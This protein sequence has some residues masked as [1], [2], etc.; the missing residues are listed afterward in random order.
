M[1]VNRYPGAATLSLLALSVLWGCNASDEPAADYGPTATPATYDPPEEDDSDLDGG[2]EEPNLPPEQEDAFFRAMPAASDRYVFVVNPERDTLS[3]INATTRAVYTLPVGLH[4]TQ[5]LTGAL[6][7]N[8]AVVLNEGDA[9]LSLLDVSSDT[10][11]TLPI[12]PDTNYM[13]LS[14]DGKYVITWFEANVEGADNSVD[15]VRSYS[16][17]SVVFTGDEKQA[18]TSTP[19]AVALNPRGATY[20][21]SSNQALVLCDGV[22]AQVYLSA[23]PTVRLIPLTD[24]IDEKLTVAEMKVSPDGR[25]AFLRLSSSAELMVVS[26]QAESVTE[27]VSRVSLS[28]PATDMDLAS[29]NLILVD[30]AQQELLIFDAQDPEAPP[31]TLQTPSNQLVGSLVISPSLNRAVLYTTL[32]AQDIQDT[33]YEDMPLDRFSLWDL[34]TD[35]IKLYDLVKPVESVSMAETSAGDVV[36]FIHQASASS[37]LTAFN[38]K[39]AL[40]HFYVE[41]GQVLPAVLEAPL[42]AQATVP[43]GQYGFAILENVNSVLVVDYAIRQMRSLALQ[44]RPVFVG[45]LTGTTE[46]YVSQEHELGRISFVNPA[47]LQATTITGFELNAQP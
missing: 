41:D 33:P 22:V 8:L 1:N 37:D 3:K 21:P 20:I 13:A 46:G 6:N 36:T 2:S 16:N 17:I 30:R 19:L 28:A 9:T 15:G 45:V 32:T 14:A 40:S 10:L 11:D 27:A 31:R 43:G 42:K 38:K 4:P 35:Q 7:P 24:N 39:N 23:K 12:H 44:S 25:F 18:P 47:T 29:N 26:L 34:S 5:V